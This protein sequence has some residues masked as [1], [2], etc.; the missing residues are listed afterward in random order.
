MVEDDPQDEIVVVE[1]LDMLEWVEEEVVDMTGEVEDGE[2]EV[3]HAL[4]KVEAGALSLEAALLVEAGRSDQTPQVEEE[5]EQTYWEGEMVEEYS[6]VE[7]DE[8]LI[9]VEDDIHDLV[10]VEISD[11]E[12]EEDREEAERTAHDDCALTEEVE[13]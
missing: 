9:Q 13:H 8:P 6:W 12:E 3:V 11:E 10:E 5:V 7:D 2:L 1:A 4:I